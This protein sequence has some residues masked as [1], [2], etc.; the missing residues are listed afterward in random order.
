ME[1]NYNYLKI[2]KIN[3]NKTMKTTTKFIFLFAFIF[4]IGKA[5]GQ[6]GIN[7]TGAAPAT[8][9][10]L[11]VSSTTK[12]LLMP[13]MTTIQRNTLTAT[14]TDGLTVYDTDTKSYWYYRTL[15][16]GWVELSTGGTSPWAISGANITN[17]NTG[18]V[19][20]GSYGNV[21]K[22]EVNTTMT[23]VAG[24]NGGNNAFIGVRENGL[25]RGYFGSYS[26]DAA[27]VDLGTNGVNTAGKLHLTTMASPKLTIIP[28][29]KVGI[30]TTS[31]TYKLHVEA[32]AK[33]GI[34]S[35][36]TIATTDS[37]A[38]IGVLDLPTGANFRAA[39]VRGE[40]KST[41]SS[42]IGVYGL[43]NGG[44]WGVAGSVKEAGADGW[45][46]GVYGEAG[47]N[48]VPTGTGG[49]G[50]SGV[51]INPGGNGGYFI[52]YNAGGA[53]RALKTSGKL[54]F[55][56]IGEAADKVLT[57]DASGN[58]SW[59]N[60][61]VGANTWTVSGV[62]INN[63]NTGG[64]G[65][66]TNVIDNNTKLQVLNSGESFVK[67]QTAATNKLAAFTAKNPDHEWFFGLNVGNYDDGRFNLFHKNTADIGSTQH[68]TITATG[69]VGIG[70]YT[71]LLNAPTERLE[72]KDGYIKVSGTNK[73]AFVITAGTGSTIFGNRVRFSYPGMSSTDILIV[74]HQF[75]A[76]YIGAVG[77]WYDSVVN[78]WS[79]FRE[80]NLA[81]PVG[82]KFTVLVI[83]Q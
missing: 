19:G 9:A 48:G 21:Y 75:V 47:L 35:R 42:S 34:Y 81:M 22:F 1:K 67:V 52:N 50:V 6:V 61:P 73:T 63:T 16:V 10:M 28:D 15:P 64:V 41:T 31:P 80:D 37:A 82:E 71:G 2:E 55:T 53:S 18:G 74:N 3:K 17:T 23:E 13:R 77:N 49:N 43:Q 20:I 51:N 38:I 12:G 59:S 39:G 32:G 5:F 7:S 36:S 79:I 72:I 70:D 76:S 69:N 33:N 27:D 78:Q 30:G 56:G 45:G 57:T 66:G 58:A 11:D 60:L 46:A 54:Q 14:A 8:N 68:L 26:G 83:K 44:G 29:G 40:S 24:F 25:Y 62:N 65:I 4:I